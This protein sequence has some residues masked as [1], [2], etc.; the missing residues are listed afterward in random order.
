M[1]AASMRPERAD[2]DTG[3]ERIRRAELKLVSR[4]IHPGA[5]VLEI[6]GGSGFQAA[7]LAA[8][9]CEVVSIDVVQHSPKALG[10]RKQYWPVQPYDGSHFPARDR[11][12]DVVYSSHMLHHV[13]AA[14]P[15]FLAEM[16]RVLRPGGI[17][18][19]VVPSASWRWWTN[20]ACY[21]DLFRRVWVGMTAKRPASPGQ[22]SPAG[23]VPS[24]A[25]ATRLK[26]LLWPQSLGPAPNTTAEL[27]AFRR[28]RWNAGFRQ[29]GW[30]VESTGGGL[31]YTGYLFLPGLPIPFRKWMARLLGSSSHVIV[32]R[33]PEPEVPDPQ[34]SR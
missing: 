28:A 4:W 21:V 14:M 22:V 8:G 25:L 32:A 1:V 27:I 6:G 10:F 23:T 30:D 12:F 5:K 9:G 15:V 16:Q 26:R 3:H 18:V 33:P 34:G 13:A 17:T 29:A 31:F 2:C 7:L 20:A 11:E 24:A 19:H